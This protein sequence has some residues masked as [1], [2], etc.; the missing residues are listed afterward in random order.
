MIAAGPYASAVTTRDPVPVEDAPP[1]LPPGV[2][3]EV[4]AGVIFIIGPDGVAQPCSSERIA[5]RVAES[6]RHLT[7][8]SR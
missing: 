5:R 8:A 1:V 4:R 7:P 6:V 2:R 3:R